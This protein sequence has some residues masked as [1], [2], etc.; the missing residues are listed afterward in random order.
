MLS[1]SVSKWK[2]PT[3]SRPD[4]KNHKVKE[5]QIGK[6]CSLGDVIVQCL[7]VTFDIGAEMLDVELQNLVRG[8]S[9]GDGVVSHGVTFELYE[10]GL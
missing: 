2:L 10:L 7:G 4:L 9:L 6:G 3:L 8:C 1:C 5:V